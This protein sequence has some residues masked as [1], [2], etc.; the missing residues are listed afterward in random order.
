[1]NVA[2]LPDF[3]QDFVFEQRPIPEPGPGQV[4][5]KV[6]A[7]GAGLSLEHARMGRMGGSTPRIMGNELSA[8]VVR[9]GPG[10][11]GWER[12]DLVTSSF[13]LLCG[14][15]EWCASGRESL[16]DNFRGFVGI[17]A[18]GAYAEY[19][20]LPAHNLVRIPEG[21]SAADAGIVADAIGTPYHAVR[22]RLKT[23]PGDAVVIIGAGGGVG[24]HALAVA[25]AFGAR[26]I[27]VERDAQK[28]AELERRGL[29]DG[30]VTDLDA[31]RELAGGQINGIIDT[32]GSSATLTAAVTAIGKAGTVVVLG[33]T[34]GAS[35]QVDPFR[36]FNEEL[37]VTGTRYTTRAEIAAVL[38]LVA[39]GGIVPVIGARFPL[40]QLNEAYAATREN[41][42]FGRIMIDVADDDGPA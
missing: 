22:E 10:V 17:A 35:I 41:K 39:Q 5:L 31:A 19:T 16:C 23:V 13:Y 21:V 34:P 28:I 30:V 12:N 7:V 33:F 25:R 26:A 24:V 1:M 27:A 18:D 36:T 32:V 3:G 4:L 2:V 8:R 15:C 40:S 29:A 9:V 6:I 20:V 37:V 14:T 42:V 11:L 38:R